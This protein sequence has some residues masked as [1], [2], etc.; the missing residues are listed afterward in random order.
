MMD[1]N[2]FDG[3]MGSSKL[4]QVLVPIVVYMVGQTLLSRTRLLNRLSNRPQLLRGSRV[5]RNWAGRIERGMLRFVGFAAW[6]VGCD[7]GFYIVTGMDVWRAFSLAGLVPYTIVQ[8]IFYRLICQKML[9]SGLWNPLAWEHY[10]TPSL[11]R[12]KPIRRL[13]SKFFHEDMGATSQHVPMRRVLLK[14]WADLSAIVL[15][16][17]VFTMGIFYVQSGELNIAPLTEFPFFMYASFYVS[18][19]LTFILGYNLGEFVL[20][21]MK[22]ALATWY[23]KPDGVLPPLWWRSLAWRT[24]MFRDAFRLRGVHL[25]SCTAGVLAVLFLMVP[26]KA[27]IDSAITYGQIQWFY[28]YG[29]LDKE[30]LKQ[31]GPKDH[32]TLPNFQMNKEQA[33]RLLQKLE[34]ARKS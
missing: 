1:L 21:R 20:V 10:R 33:E 7:L 28:A 24:R 12:T 16:W 32:A 23:E 19:I 29:E 30:Q 13:L 6:K 34:A 3:A 9:F 27:Q 22:E 25:G 14:P 31:L 5:E 4:L 2:V 26:L 18:G 15:A 11:E 17:S 8:Y